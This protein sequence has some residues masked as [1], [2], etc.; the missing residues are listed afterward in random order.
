M[1]KKIL[2]ISLLFQ[3]AVLVFLVLG[4]E[5]NRNGQRGISLFYAAFTIQIIILLML[6]YLVINKHKS[7]FNQKM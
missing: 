1:A 4:I 5:L 7:K 6:I 2:C 3:F